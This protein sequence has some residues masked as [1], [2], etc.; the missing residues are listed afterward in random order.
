M[1]ELEK[2]ERK[3]NPELIDKYNLVCNELAK[4]DLPLYKCLDKVGMSRRTFYDLVFDK[5]NLSQ[6]LAR[7]RESFLDKHIERIVEISEDEKL[8]V[9]EKKVRI[10]AI[11][12]AAQLSL[13][14]RYRDK[15]ETQVN[16]QT[17]SEI[18][19]FEIPQDG[20]DRQ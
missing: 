10:Y 13:P 8:S 6:N 17:N 5:Q 1:S 7:A 3:Y 4:G 12:K 9:D 2:K 15:V 19:R 16:I 18:V 14:K 20:R 11:E